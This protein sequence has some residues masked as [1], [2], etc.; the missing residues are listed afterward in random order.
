MGRWQPAAAIVAAIVV[1]GVI[2]GLTVAVTWWAQ[3]CWGPRET[4]QRA[5]YDQPMERR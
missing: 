3:S 4:C 2:T 5:Q 1:V